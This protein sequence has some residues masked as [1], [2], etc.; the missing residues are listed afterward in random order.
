MK[1][2]SVRTLYFNSCI[3]CYEDNVPIGRILFFMNAIC[4]R[5]LRIMQHYK[6]T[7]NKLLMPII[8]NQFLF[9]LQKG[10]LDSRWFLTLDH[11]QL[12]KFYSFYIPRQ[13]NCNLL[14]T[15]NGLSHP[16]TAR[17]LKKGSQEYFLCS[18][19]EVNRLQIIKRISF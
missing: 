7:K 6:F 9:F 17:F 2:R 15:R 4:E 1:I 10:V 19:V 16:Y 14:T 13:R 11:T 3:N 8:E 5:T 12:V 18:K